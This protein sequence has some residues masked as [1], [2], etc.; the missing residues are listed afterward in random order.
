MTY[1]IIVDVYL[2][3]LVDDKHLNRNESKDPEFVESWVGEHRKGA[4]NNPDTEKLP[5]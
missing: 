1:H 4:K 5:L 3:R 2:R